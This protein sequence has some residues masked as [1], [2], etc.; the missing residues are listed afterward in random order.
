MAF[1]QSTLKFIV[2]IITFKQGSSALFSFM[3]A[4]SIT[5]SIDRFNAIF[6][7][8]TDPKSIFIPFLIEI[9]MIFAYLGMTSLD[10]ILGMRVAIRVRKEQFQIDK[11][12][13]TIIK[14]I[15]IILI[16]S[17]MMFLA[18]VSES[19]GNTT[20]WWI[21][22]F[23]LCFFW[24]LSVGFEFASI[25]RNFETLRGSKYAIFQ[26]WDKIL[27]VLENKFIRK[28]E[29]SSFNILPDEDEKDNDNT[30]NPTP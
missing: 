6:L 3:T 18:F 12:F 13:D 24:I 30:N 29:S 14:A 17:V 16:T 1:A 15:A 28:I 21:S 23:S 10:F 27:V 7:K 11:L 4:A 19:I 9:V 8:D 20:F 5:L 22:F 25:G 2:K 26:F